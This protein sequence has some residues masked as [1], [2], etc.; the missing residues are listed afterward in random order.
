MRT[1]FVLAGGGSLGA[2]EVGMTLA[3]AEAFVVPDLLVG[4]S[5][6]AVNSAFLAGRP[7][8]D[9]ARA[10]RAVWVGLR[11]SY[12][13]PIG[14]L[15]GLLG[16]LGRRHYLVDP[17]R[18]RALLERHLVQELLERSAVPCTVVASDVLSG[19]EVRL[20]QGPAVEAVLASVAIPGIFP[21]V[22]IGDRALADGAMA[23]NT[24]IAA[25]VALGAQRIVVLPTG[26]SCAIESPPRSALAMM[27]HAVNRIIAQQLVVDI[28]R[29]SGVAALSVVPPLCPLAVSAG[30]FTHSVELI[31]RAQ[32]TTREWLERGGLDSPGV[33]GPLRPH[34]HGGR[35][36]SRLGS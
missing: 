19:E 14:L 11:R 31:D 2:I 34:S 29:F 12:I 35:D 3:L 6:G 4:S 26:F 20:S 15:D 5:V 8:L 24:P 21:H 16:F 7:G 18:M 1:A 30:D 17:A 36:G 27:L 33:P 13:F 9:G 23:S 22:R 32:A 28:E 10:L 25:A